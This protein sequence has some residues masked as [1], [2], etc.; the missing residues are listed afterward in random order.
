MAQQQPHPYRIFVRGLAKTHVERNDEGIVEEN[1]LGY[2]FADHGCKLKDVRLM[3][4]PSTNRCRGFGFVDL[5]DEDSLH[6][7]LKF[8]G[9]KDPA[10]V[11]LD[12]NASG[13]VVEA[14]K[15]AQKDA[16]SKHI[17]LAKVRDRTE[18]MARELRLK[19]AKV[20]EL[21][22]ELLSQQIRQSLAEKQKPLEAHL[23][24][25]RAKQERMRKEGETLE[26][27]EDW[28]RSALRIEEDRT[29]AVEEIVHH[30][31]P[32]QTRSAA[33]DEANDGEEDDDTTGAYLRIK[34]TFYEYYLPAETTL[35]RTKTAPPSTSTYTGSARDRDEGYPTIQDASVASSSSRRPV[36]SPAPAPWPVS[37]ET[38]TDNSSHILRSIL[39]DKMQAESGQLPNST[40]DDARGALRSSS[41][42]GTTGRKTSE[43]G[44]GDADR[45]GPEVT[46]GRSAPGGAE[47]HIGQN[48][49]DSAQKKALVTSWA[50][51]SEDD[52]ADA[53]VQ[54]V[55][56]I[57][58]LPQLSDKE[59]EDKLREELGRLWGKV[60]RR[61]PPSIESIKITN[62]SD[63][64]AQ[65][66][67][68]RDHGKAATVTFTH[69]QDATWLVDT[70]QPSNWSSAETLSLHGRVLHAEWPPQAAPVDWRKLAFKAD[71]DVSSQ[72]SY[73]TTGTK[74]SFS[75]VVEARR[76]D[77]SNASGRAGENPA[78]N[79]TV[80]LTG[81]SPEL[82]A[83]TVRSEVL[84]LLRRL[85]Q[86]DGYRFDPE[87][88]LHRG[89]EGIVAGRSKRPREENDGSCQVK[90]RSYADAKWLVESAKGLN[91][92]GRSLRAKWAR[93]KG[94][95]G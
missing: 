79:R 13:L 19:E 61:T 48:H 34:N 14:A 1:N 47:N 64:S 81:I 88:K 68:A 26:Q 43:E 15:P 66:K 73:E 57:R 83:H 23:A 90:L 38:R 40:T 36:P 4:D 31:D 87:A 20:Q 29:R 17:E 63:G 72:I 82:P 6:I 42:G 91:I 84:S 60:R 76:L 5:A 92:E 37:R 39:E 41:R 25:E 74:H 30:V 46:A 78:A 89:E 2:F 59:L 8:A 44:T 28:L 67:S 71:T 58:N 69:P 94:G 86:R 32:E 53:C 77:P 22:R 62:H 65:G 24:D 3:V 51:A 9:T 85:W 27:R 95:S 70:R 93:P 56:R 55:V 21:E 50:D 45:S 33:G 11:K 54:T 18:A 80:I 52:D 12:A 35:V 7:A 10:N 49:Q 16:Q 75:N